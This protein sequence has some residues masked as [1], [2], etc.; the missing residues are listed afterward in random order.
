LKY[1]N[2]IHKEEKKMTGTNTQLTQFNNE[3]FGS[4]RALTIDG[5]AWFVGKDV[6]EALGYSNTKDALITHVSAEDK[7]IIQRSENA[8]FE[9]PNRGLAVI[10]ESGLYSLI[11]GSKLPSA[12]KFAHW[13]TSEVLPSIRKHG[14]YMTREVLDKALTS[15]D[16]LIE[17]ATKLKE[18]QEKNEELQKKIEEDKPKTIFADA[19]SVSH[20]SVLVGALAKILK[21][22]GLDIGQNR[23]FEALRNDGYLVKR[24]GSDYNM[25]TQR[26]MELGLFEIKER[27]INNPDGSTRITKTPLV[28][29]KGQVYFVNRFL[30]AS[31]V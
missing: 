30:G 16:F 18:E 21:Q 27:T 17:L 5:E 31:A 13:V 29:G 12:Q 10:N 23:L 14:A 20:T 15:P 25:P 2:I 9:I 11:F 19:V 6:A 28:T 8:T 4:V 3:E 26:A 22:N 7:Q 24:K 1:K